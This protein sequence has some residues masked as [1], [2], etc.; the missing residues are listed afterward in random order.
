MRTLNSSCQTNSWSWDTKDY[1]ETANLYQ[2]ISDSSRRYGQAPYLIPVEE[3]LQA[4]SFTDL[5][6]F[7]LEMHHYLASQNILHQQRVAVI[8]PNSTLMALLYLTIIGSGRVLIPINPKSGHGEIE[9]ILDKTAPD[10]LICSE[11][12]HTKVPESFPGTVEI[13]K[14]QAAF[15]S[16]LMDGGHSGKNLCFEDK[17]PIVAEIV[18]TS[19]TTGNPKGVVLTHKNILADSFAIGKMFDFYEG[20][21]FLTTTPMFHNSGQIPTTT[22]PLWCGGST[23]PI[24]PELGL[25]KLDH[26]VH[27]YQINWSFV[28]PSFLAFL[29]TA[30]KTAD[31]STL[32][33]LFVGGAKLSPALMEQ[34]ETKFNIPLYEA[35]GLTETTSF[36]T[37][38][39]KDTTQ[40][41]LDSAGIPLFINEIRI[42]SSV[43]QSL[44]DQ[45]LGE[46]LIKGDNVFREYLDQPEL[47]EEKIRD[48]WFFSGDLGYLKGKDLFVLDRKDNMILV[49]GENVYPAEVERHVP[50]L[51]GI[52]D[53]V[54]TSRPHQIL[55][56]ELVL[57]Y[58]IEEGL[59]ANTALWKKTLANHISNFK[60]PGI[61]ID[62]NTL[63]T[64]G[65]PRASNGKILKKILYDMVNHNI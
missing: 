57:V 33:G 54:L 37:C 26:F 40:R 51:E 62:A 53:G 21:N 17:P 10:L 45:E 5:H 29:M 59:D 34:F 63:E 20:M 15:I 38:V 8:Y 50:L 49:G 12:T 46:I 52:V 48:G 24:R 35:Y 7:T 55:G 2:L 11:I 23:T 56:N 65:I 3:N 60:I 36:A 39:R 25:I 58:E 47:T 19:G 42:D 6:Q 28:T 31:I 30:K 18:F 4:L 22:V 44:G 14:D 41:V 16:D 9:Y 64:Q 32:E 61:F 27:K 43:G 13:V 1:H